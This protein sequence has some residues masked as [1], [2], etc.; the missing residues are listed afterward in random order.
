M[1]T[2]VITIAFVLLSI[3]PAAAAIA[4]TTSLNASVNPARLGQTVILTATVAPAPGG[5]V[6]FYDGTAVIGVAPVAAGAASLQIASLASG[7]HSVFARYDGDATHGPST[8]AKLPLPV[9]SLPAATFLKLSPLSAINPTTALALD[10]NNDRIPDLVA[11][12]PDGTLNI[13]LGRGDGTFAA[14]TTLSLNAIQVAAGDFNGDGN[15][16]LAVTISQT[17]TIAVLLGAGDGTFSATAIIPVSGDGFVLAIQATDFNADGMTDILV[18]RSA[19]VA[20]LPGNGDGTFG[21][22][23]VTPVPE[24]YIDGL[25]VADFNLDGVPDLITFSNTYG[26]YYFAGNGDGTFTGGAAVGPFGPSYSLIAADFNGDGKPDL[27]S[28]GYGSQVCLGNGDGTFAAPVNLD[29]AYTLA[30]DV[31]GDGKLD[32]LSATNVGY[33]NG[34]GTFQP[35]VTLGGVGTLLTVADFNNNGQIDLLRV[36]YDPATA[37]YSPSVFLGTNI[38]TVT[39][40][41][42]PI[43]ATYNAPVTFS[44]TV[45]PQS[46]TGTVGFYDGDTLLGSTPVASGFATVTANAPFAG[47]RVFTAVYSGDNVTQPAASTP[48]TVVV[49]G[50]PSTT[51]LS[52]STTAATYGQTLTLT[53]TVSPSPTTGAVSFLDG[54]NL[55]G[56]APVSHGIAT[57]STAALSTGT[58]SLTAQYDGG[59]SISLSSSAALLVTVNSLRAG[60]F[61]R[62]AP[63]FIPGEPALIFSADLNHDGNSDLILTGSPGS[64]DILLAT[65]PGTFAAPVTYA[66]PAPPV[67]VLIA[68][69]NGDGA[70]DLIVQAANGLSILLGNGDGTFRTGVSIVLTT[71]Q[72]AAADINRDGR[73]DLIVSSPQAT[74]LSILLGNGDGT[75]QPSF[76]SVSL[77]QT[78]PFAVA[79]VNGDG[80]PDIVESFGGSVVVYSGNGDGTFGTLQTLIFSGGAQ[81]IAIGDVNH[82]GHPDLIIGCIGSLTVI[83]GSADGQFTAATSYSFG[84]YGQF[85]S[86][87]DIDGDG[88][89][90][91]IVQGS[92]IGIYLGNGDGTFRPDYGADVSG[93]LAFGDFFHTGRVS[94]ASIDYGNLILTAGVRPAT[95]TLSATPSPGA[96]GQPVTLTAAISPSD[97]TGTVTFLNNY[98]LIATVPVNSGTATFTTSAFP[99]NRQPL[100]SQYSGDAITSYANSNSFIE[101]IVGSPSAV[102]MSASAASA[103]FGKS[104][105]FTA[106]ITPLAATGVITF[107]AG[108]QVLGSAPLA[109]GVASFTTAS[110]PAGTSLV[111]AVYEGNPTYTAGSASPSVAISVTT[112]AGSTFRAKPLSTT[113]YGQAVASADFNGDGIA[114]LLLFS[115][116]FGYGNSADVLLGAGDGTFSLGAQIGFRVPI[117]LSALPHY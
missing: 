70:P 24:P 72:I 107:F 44:A 33:G 65:G 45:S 110:L 7:L 38:S 106:S 43:P 102:S 41:V 92:G 95:V 27:L 18:S 89:P 4:T 22:P 105:T 23:I 87:L 28:E 52:A 80:I 112:V 12:Q 67:G 9:T 47:R 36:I 61:I 63:I 100:I 1:F 56:S 6:T 90:D 31:N 53:A 64:V 66:V 116:N 73:I 30:A 32:V 19:S 75:F 2:L 115:S 79:D 98:S 69:V 77:P 55:I 101:T 11:V 15:I 51:T 97:A 88:N 57:L 82:D 20:V 17:D 76:Q 111:R 68:D 48:L 13:L 113:P 94:A 104:L 25:T 71:S 29:A 117:E 5:K 8:S 35:T 86:I 40:S 62:S 14:G 42:S 21:P 50:T 93:P 74:S 81:S 16:D 114:D 34:D 54:A 26:E 99:A 108:T 103:I 49:N 78:G 60:S 10:L 58:H 109:N 59:G 84:L 91:V 46:A 85:I 96:L 83:L 39:L 3:D 37:V